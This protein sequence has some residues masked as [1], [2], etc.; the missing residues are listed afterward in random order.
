MISPEKLPKSSEEEA[1]SK[2]AEPLNVTPDE[3]TLPVLGQTTSV[4]PLASSSTKTKGK[5]KSKKST[6]DDI[7]E[8]V[9]PTPFTPSVNKILNSRTDSLGEPVEPPSLPIGMTVT[10]LRARLDP[11]KKTKC[12]E[13]W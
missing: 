9:L 13:H 6:N 10:S 5:G 2:R 4:Q 12:V 1:T 11:K 8:N 7:Q 3:D